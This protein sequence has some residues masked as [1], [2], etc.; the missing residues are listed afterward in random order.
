MDLP[1]MVNISYYTTR[2][3]RSTHCVCMHIYVYHAFMYDIIS[4]CRNRLLNQRYVCHK[5]QARS[6]KSGQRGPIRGAQSKIA[7]SLHA[8]LL[9]FDRK[10]S[11]I[12]EHSESRGASVDLFLQAQVNYDDTDDSDVDVYSGNAGE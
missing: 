2:Q 6:W 11:K 7:N 4:V 3:M 1:V 9:G 5:T 8:L 12:V 10:F